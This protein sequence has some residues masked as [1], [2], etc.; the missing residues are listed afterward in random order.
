MHIKMEAEDLPVI[1]NL[2]NERI[3][4]ELTIEEIGQ[5]SGGHVMEVRI[6]G[7]TIQAREGAWAVWHTA[8]KKDGPVAWGE[9]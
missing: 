9:A 3:A 2:P 7:F 5:V 4:R 6:L 1:S 8:S